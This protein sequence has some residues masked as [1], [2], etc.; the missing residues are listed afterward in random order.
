MLRSVRCLR[1]RLYSHAA[2]ALVLA[3]AP[4][5]APGSG[6]QMNQ[7]QPMEEISGQGRGDNRPPAG[8][9][10]MPRL[11]EDPIS[12]RQFRQA[13][14]R[15]KLHERPAR[16]VGGIWQVPYID[17]DPMQKQG[18]ALDGGPIGMVPFTPLGQSSSMPRPPRIGRMIP[19][20]SACLPAF[21][22]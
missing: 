15:R 2:S 11:L 6:A 12:R 1:L 10:K 19:R 8:P 4:P 16:S 14:S 3:R 21:R 5:A 22:A 7:A 13:G 18:K 17:L 20:A 9:A